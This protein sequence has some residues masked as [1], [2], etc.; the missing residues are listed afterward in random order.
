M[1]FWPKKLIL[2]DILINALW[3]LLAWIMWS[4]FILIITFAL[5][6]T[7]D[8]PSTFAQTQ[9][10]TKTSSVFPLILSIITFVWTTITVF[11]TYFILSMTYPDRYKRNVIIF[12]Q[13]WFFSI[14]TYIFIAPVYI[15]TW[16]IDY[17]NIMI[18]F[19]AHTLITTFWTS[20]ILEILNN[21][22]YILIWIYWSF[23][24]LFLSIFFTIFIFTSFTWWY[25]KLI[26]LLFLLPIINF[27]TT[28][29]KQIFELWYYHYFKYTAQDNLWD[30]FSQIELEEK[31]ILRLEEEK[32]SI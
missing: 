15:Y 22:R 30:I 7:M 8:I 1:W 16:V 28:F 18:V 25:A 26:S 20:I 19:L 31:E 5:W 32:N 9:I 13:I 23:I 6:S 29:F 4:I 24:G 27:T 14:L 3:S 2:S 11:L 21:Y 17:N 12:G 10:W